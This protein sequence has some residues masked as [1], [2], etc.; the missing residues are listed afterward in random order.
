VPGVILPDVPVQVPGRPEVTRL[1]E[2]ARDGLLALAGP[3]VDVAAMGQALAE[4]AGEVPHALLA[5]EEIE[6]SGILRA[7]LAVRQG[8]V[9]LVRP[10]AHTCAVVSGPAELIAA[11][12]RALGH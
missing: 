10:D 3:A 5:M 4:G 12:R 9:W 7:S 6:P 1:R 11:A 2:L 8:E